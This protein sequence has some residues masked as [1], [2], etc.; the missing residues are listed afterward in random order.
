MKHKY[1]EMIKAKADN[2][3]LVW[4]GSGFRVDWVEVGKDFPDFTEA[5]EYFLCLPKHKDA[6]LH[7]LNG[8]EVEFYCNGTWRSCEDW[9]KDQSR[10]TYGLC[11]MTT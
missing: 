8:G 6:C 9:S 4:L 3:E 11:V 2:T 7:W 5:T 1:A 10:F